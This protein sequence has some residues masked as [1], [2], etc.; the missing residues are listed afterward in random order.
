MGQLGGLT[1]AAHRPDGRDAA[2]DGAQRRC[3]I[4][5][6]SSGLFLN[7]LVLHVVHPQPCR[8]GAIERLTGLA[9]E[10]PAINRASRLSCTYVLPAGKLSDTIP[11][12]NKR[13]HR[14]R[15]LKVSAS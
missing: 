6:P 7:C 15:L 11:V 8:C 4:L 5:A 3:K 12:R 14:P 9:Y 1:A 13:I 10:P 2:E